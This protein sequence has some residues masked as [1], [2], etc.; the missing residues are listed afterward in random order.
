MLRAPIVT[1][2]LA[3]GLAC[4]ASEP[5]DDASRCGPT[6]EFGNTGCGEVAGVVTRAGG[7]AV[8]GALVAVEGPVDSARDVTLVSGPVQSSAAGAYQVRAVR[9]SEAIPTTGPDTV[10]VWVRAVLPPPPGTPD[11][12]RG[13]T[14]SVQA[15]LELRPVG[16]SPVVVQ[17]APLVLPP[18]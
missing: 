7:V 13:A 12:T 15:T 18:T 11:G 6:G 17:A 10:T 3:L 8:S 2:T 5:S 14:D 16:A 9:L 1:T 4:A